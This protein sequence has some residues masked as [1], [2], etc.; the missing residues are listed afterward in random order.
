MRELLVLSGERADGGFEIADLV[1][2][3]FSS[4]LSPK[5]P[6]TRI[7]RCGAT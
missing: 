7:S 2:E 4:S 3:A 6:A 1:V 5:R